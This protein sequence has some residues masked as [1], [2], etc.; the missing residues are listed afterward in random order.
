[1]SLLREAEPET[2]SATETALQPIIDDSMVDFQVPRDPVNSRY[3]VLLLKELCKPQPGLS[4]VSS[5][6]LAPLFNN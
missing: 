3:G 5:I 4:V 2:Q 1:M 6:I